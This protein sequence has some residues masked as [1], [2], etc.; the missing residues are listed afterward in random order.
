MVYFIYLVYRPSEKLL[1]F[2]ENNKNRQRIQELF[3]KEKEMAETIDFKSIY[4]A[5]LHYFNSEKYGYSEADIH[6]MID[7]FS[8]TFCTQDNF[9][10]V[11]SNIK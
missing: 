9:K 10:S 6:E 1:G 4:G 5:I 8:F 7:K 3:N 2:V 11:V